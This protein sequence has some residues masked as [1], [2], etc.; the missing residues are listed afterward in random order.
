M[1]K[2]RGLRGSVK[3]D[4]VTEELVSRFC[5]V[6]YES[7]PYPGIILAVDD[8]DIEVKVMHS[9]GKNRFFWPMIDDV[10]WYKPDDVIGLLENPPN[11]SLTAT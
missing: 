1:F 2:D 11:K 7:K 5:V 6:N 9:V 8:E 4:D 3:V 10:L